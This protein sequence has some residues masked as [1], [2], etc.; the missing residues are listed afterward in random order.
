MYF[1][2]GNNVSMLLELEPL[3]NLYYITKKKL[4]NT[5]L[6]LMKILGV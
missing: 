6:F 5:H 1:I 2:I 3:T 4:K